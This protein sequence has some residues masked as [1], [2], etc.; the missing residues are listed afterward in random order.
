MRKILIATH[1]YLAD[2]LK[3]TVEFIIGERPDI[4]ILTAYV[5]ENFDI[6]K[7]IESVFSHLSEK[8]DLIVLVD[9]LGG[10]VSN[11]FAHYHERENFY[12]ISGVNLPLVLEVVA[13]LEQDTGKVIEKG[14]ASGKQG[15]LFVNELFGEEENF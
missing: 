12:L 3:K 14:I 9:I 15:I 6:I 8:D 11:A 4:S 5:E 2:G 10:S 13:S 1:S 7:E